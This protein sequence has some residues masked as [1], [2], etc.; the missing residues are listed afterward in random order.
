MQII[1]IDIG[2]TAVCGVVLDAKTKK[3]ISSKTV[4]SNAFL[5]GEDFERIQSV[6][7]IIS[8]ADEILEGFINDET[9][10][11]GVTGQMHGI[12][13]YDADG[14]AVSPLYTW[15]D[16]RGEQSFG[17][18]TYAEAM[19]SHT[20][21]GL[22][23]DFYNRQNGLVP[24][25]AVG[26]CTIHDYFVMRLCGLKKAKMHT[27]D[28][29]SLGCFDLKTN[30][31][32]VDCGIDVTAELEIA[33]EHNGIPVCVAIGDNQASV[34]AS[35]E[36]TSD[37]LINIGT[38][39]Q[40]SVITDKV[41]E[42]DS[43]ET[44]PFFDGKFLAVG[45]ALC[46]GRAYAVL[47]D[48]YKAVLSHVTEID[49]GEVYKIMDKMLADVKSSPLT[50]DTR[51]SGTR[52][53]QSIKGSVKNISFDSFTPENLTY[54]LLCGMIDELYGMYEKMDTK[55]V[56][57]VGSGNGLRLNPTLQRIAEEKFGSAL[58]LPP[59]TEEAACGAALSVMSALNI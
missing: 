52:A 10:G 53:D 29:A 18:S 31:F 36:D 43:I 13:Y 3:V 26:F 32:T 45:A 49:D 8:I 28:A 23:T 21:Y 46:G 30:R 51:F 50:V 7:K 59:Y 54:G 34:L 19:G 27:T 40:V 11:I 25:S 58:K 44:R 57:A 22:V 2:T 47:K 15:Q 17:D 24:Q 42:A 4:N 12:V 16:K 9:A 41:I 48:F 14:K 37:V 35:L 1:G 55:C 5:E 56:G 39:S 6:D 20:G 38:G 33:G